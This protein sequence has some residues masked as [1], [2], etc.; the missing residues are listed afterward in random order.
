VDLT[1]NVTGST[2]VK[3]DQLLIFLKNQCH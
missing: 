3:G 1:T 2:C